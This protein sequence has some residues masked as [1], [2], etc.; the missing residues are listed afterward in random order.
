VAVDL[1]QLGQL[2]VDEVEGGAC[3]AV[4]D[5]EQ[6]LLGDDV[7]GAQAVE[8]CDNASA[9]TPLRRALPARLMTAP[10]LG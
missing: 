3:E 5:G 4:L 7:S 6:P 9:S 8:V 10:F 2:V 1:G